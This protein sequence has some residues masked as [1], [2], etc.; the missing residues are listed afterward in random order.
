MPRDKKAQTKLLRVGQI[1]RIFMEKDKI[2]S[3][4]LSKEFQTTP[5]TIQRDLLL[6]KEAGFPIHEI[7]KGTYQLHKDIVKNLEVFDDTELA[8]MVALKNVVS[9]LGQPFQKAVDRVLERLYESAASMPVFVK[10]DDAMPLDTTY[11]N[12]M[13]KAIRDKKHL[14]FQYTSREKAVHP[15]QME[16]Y[17]VV[18]FEGFW[19]LIGNETATGILKRY[20]LDKIKDLKLLKTGFKS[21]PKNLDAVLQES[22]NIWF[23]EKATLDVE[24]LIDAQVSNYFKR[25]KMFPTQQIKEEKPDGSLVI[26]FRVGHEEAIRNLLKSWIPHVSILGPPDFR[27]QFVQEVKEWAQKQ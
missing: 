26:T 21:M 9:Q 17:R 19:Y 1:L 10:I 23:A 24:V 15:V 2:S 16:P 8:L 11:L 4:W 6:L 20:A 27:K 22:A 5:R 3:S 13:V 14:I 18:Y 25:R 7:Q 12:R